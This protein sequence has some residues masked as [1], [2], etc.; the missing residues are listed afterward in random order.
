MRIYD[1]L[2]LVMSGA[3]GFDLTDPYDCNVF[4][5]RSSEGWILFDAGAGREPETLEA[6]LAGDGLAGE[7][8]RH[9]FLTHGHADHAGGAAAWRERLGLS[10]YAGAAT[11]AMVTCGDEAGISLGAARAAG[12]YPD[13]YSFTAC[14]VDRVLAGG[15]VVGLGDARIE[16]VA[17]PGHSHD[18]FSYLV[19]TGTRRLLIAG[20]AIFCGGKVAIQDIYDCSVKETCDTIR[21]LGALSFDALLPGHQAF[22]LKD[23]RRHVELAMRHVRELRCPPSII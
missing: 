19:D 6:V 1:G 14:P 10:V 7:P 15:E 11:A 12:I 8:L 9:L 5:L 17:T 21:R 18:H 13:D 2:H 22:A 23:G 20:D 16:A 3:G 4:M